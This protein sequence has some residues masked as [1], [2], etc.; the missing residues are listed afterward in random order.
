M[1]YCPFCGRLLVQGAPYCASCGRQLVDPA[2][3]LVDHVRPS[4]GATVRKS[5]KDAGPRLGAH[6]HAVLAFAL[7]AAM[8]GG[9]CIAAP[10]SWADQ[11]NDI[12]ASA[13]ALGIGVFLLL[14]VAQYFIMADATRAVQPRFKMTLVVFLGVLLINLGY[15]IIINFGVLLFVVP[16][17]WAAVKL[18]PW[19]PL[20]L[21]GEEDAFSK[22]WLYTTNQ[23]WQTTALNLIAWGFFCATAFVLYVVG[24]AVVDA[25]PVAAV[26]AAPLITVAGYYVLYVTWLMWAYWAAELR[27]HGQVVA[28]AAAEALPR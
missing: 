25:W 21:Q 9:L 3:N 27:T 28:A 24:T 18:S 23:F 16:G 6:S 20:F 10:P 12:G 17:F 19:L 4:L 22:S 2:G 8:I 26:V 15:N 7:L 1:I 5:F 14:I 13:N 11:A